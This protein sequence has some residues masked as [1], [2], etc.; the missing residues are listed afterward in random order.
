MALNYYHVQGDT[1]YSTEAAASAAATAGDDVN[2]SG[3][4]TTGCRRAYE[5]FQMSKNLNITAI[6][7]G[8]SV[9]WSIL[10]Y[11]VN[12]LTGTTNIK[13]MK[14]EFGEDQGSSKLSS[15]A[16]NYINCTFDMRYLFLEGAGTHSFYNCIFKSANGHYCV[17]TSGSLTAT[18]YHCAFLT[19][20]AAVAIQHNTAA[21]T[22]NVYNSILAAQAARGGSSGTINQDHNI[23]YASWTDGGGGAGANNTVTTEDSVGF[24]FTQNGISED[25]RVLLASEIAGTTSANG[26]DLTG[27]SNLDNDIDGRS[28]STYGYKIGISAGYEVGPF[29]GGGGRRSRIQIHGV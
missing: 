4:P 26:V 23:V 1:D 9:Q 20:S 10:R 3:D 15:G 19:Q 11:I 25:A 12:N 2:V 27:I 6:E 18:F 24:A 22:L 29:S 14:F 28:R 16:V 13:G 7:D 21:V 17:L 5:P 8:I